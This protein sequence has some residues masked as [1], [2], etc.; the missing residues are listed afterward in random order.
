MKVCRK[1]PWSAS[2][3]VLQLMSA[4]SPSN[5]PGL[6]VLLHFA[7]TSL[8]VL[9]LYCMLVRPSTVSW[10][11]LPHTIKPRPRRISLFSSSPRTP[12]AI[13]PHS[14]QSAMLRKAVDAHSAAAH[15]HNSLKQQLF[16]SSSP[17]T[18]DARIHSQRYGQATRNLSTNNPLR[19]S[20]ASVLNGVDERR[21]GSKC[22]V[23]RTSSGL[24]KALG[25]TAPNIFDEFPSSFGS[26]E[27][28]IIPDH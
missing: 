1:L 18:Q 20:A 28:P 11:R 23:K 9:F 16:P 6:M 7:L 13:R 2:S 4:P 25:G 19:P 27:N 24:A 10:V 5:L 12:A 17:T 14:P 8:L 26:Q 21:A 15:S 22:A 3:L